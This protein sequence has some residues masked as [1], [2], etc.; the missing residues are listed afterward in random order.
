MVSKL[1][2]S[3]MMV[4]GGETK[5]QLEIIKEF[6][7]CCF[8]WFITG[9]IWLCEFLKWSLIIRMYSKSHLH[10]SRRNKLTDTISKRYL[11]SMGA[12]GAISLRFQSHFNKSAFFLSHKSWYLLPYMANKASILQSQKPFLNQDAPCFQEAL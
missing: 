4:S 3:I 9:C 12:I 7:G 1:S 11:D 6:T 2:T 10:L 8:G 5:L